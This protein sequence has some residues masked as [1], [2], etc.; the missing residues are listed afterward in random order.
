MIASV[1]LFSVNGLVISFVYKIL[2]IK[3]K[4]FLTLV[5]IFNYKTMYKNIENCKIVSLL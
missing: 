5:T 1:N 2:F 3:S 4:Y